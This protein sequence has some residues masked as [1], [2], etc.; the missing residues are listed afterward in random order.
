MGFLVVLLLVLPAAAAVIVAA[1]G[2]GRAELI[3]RICLGVTVADAVI[4]LILAVGLWSERGDVSVEN[5]GGR[6]HVLAMNKELT[7]FRP[8]LVPGSTQDAPHN[9]TWTL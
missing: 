5:F 6:D 8:E 7:T 9:T 4:A 1:L 2:S 3:R